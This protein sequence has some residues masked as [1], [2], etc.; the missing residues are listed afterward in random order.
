MTQEIVHQTSIEQQAVNKLRGFLTKYKSQ[1][2]GA[3]PAY[4]DTKRWAWLVINSIRK[5]PNLMNCTPVSFVNA[6]AL[7]SNLGLQVRD[8]SAY[9]VP[10]GKECQLL[11][12]YRGKID[13]AARA[14]VMIHPELIYNGERFRYGYGPNG[15][16]FDWVRA[17][18]GELRGEI[19]GA[20]AHIQFKEHQQYVVMDFAELEAI[21]KRSRNG[22]GDL[23]LAEIRATDINTVAYRDRTPWLTDPDR[24][25]VKTV[26]HRAFNYC[27]SSDEAGRVLALSQEIDDANDI[28][29]KK[30]PAAPGL[31]SL[32]DEV[33]PDDNRPLVEGGMTFEGSPE[34]VKAEVGAHKAEQQRVGGEKLKQ[35]EA[36]FAAKAKGGKA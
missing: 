26:V 1:I 29:K 28:E 8:R 16:E 25:Y 30:M 9:L 2:E 6:V 13:L 15:V 34:D 24:M 33:E 23:T 3:L 35:M 14:G 20:F 7:A 36:D 18:L 10:F 31:E 17:P 32:L 22:R 5:T 4:M 12:D 11:I 19:M 27:P 21:R